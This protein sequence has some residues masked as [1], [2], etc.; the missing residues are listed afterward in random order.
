MPRF[1]ILLAIFLA[2]SAPVVLGQEEEAESGQDRDIVDVDTC[3]TVA[4]MLVTS[5]YCR[6]LNGGR[7]PGKGW[8]YRLFPTGH[9]FSAWT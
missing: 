9:V 6:R 3:G 8:E 2:L 4:G 7:Q 5:A 1:P